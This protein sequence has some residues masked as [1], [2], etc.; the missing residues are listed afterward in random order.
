[1]YQ[2]EI[3]PVY[4]PSLS[5]L[6]RKYLLD[7]FD[8]TWISSS[9]SYLERF[10]AEFARFSGVSEAIMVSNG[11]VALHLALVALGV[12]PGDEVIVPS[13]TY[14]ASVNCIRY[15]GATPVF[16]D[17]D[18]NTW[19]I[20]P[21]TIQ[22]KISSR[23]KCILAVHLY[24]IPADLLGIKKL[25]EKYSISLVEDCAEALG[26]K[27]LD[28]HVGAFGDIATF[29]FFGNKTLTTG[30]GGAVVTNKQDLADKVRLL[31]GQGQSL[32]RRY[33]HE[34]VGYNYRMTNLAAAIGLGQLEKIDAIL[35][36]KKQIFKTYNNVV[37]KL[38][39]RRQNLLEGHIQGFWLYSFL[40][41]NERE[42]SELTNF[43]SEYGIETRPVFL[44]AHTMPMY[45]E[46]LN[47]PVSKE[48]SDCGL[49][50]PSFPDLNDNEV[51]KICQALEDFYK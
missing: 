3:I 38:G 37:A 39:L 30:E 31:K 16:V 40:A 45:S 25:C 29:S 2:T 21:N 12:G 19:A 20:S 26:A 6:E 8:S 43:L 51:S 14:I 28:R 15:V 18:P 4:R 13:F 5:D 17:I 49:S 1:M 7:A 34:V 44:L 27:I 10:E 35:Q 9:G 48:I 47:L 36:R 50:L 22:D 11:T 46:E 24:G 42:R 41:K 33:Y 32:S 23:T